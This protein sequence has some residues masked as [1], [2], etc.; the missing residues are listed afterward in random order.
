MKVLRSSAATLAVG[1]F[2]LG[3]VALALFAAPLWYTWHNTMQLSMSSVLETDANRFTEVYRLEGSEGLSNY[4]K[5]RISIPVPSGDRLLM[6]AD[7]SLKPIAGNATAWPKDV[8]AAP[9]D[10][11]VQM[12]VGGTSYQGGGSGG[13]AAG[14]LSSGGLA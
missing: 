9:G 6:F 4:I 8:P 13:A 10:Y 5:A 1:Y 3:L 7:P 12:N 14:R 2:C 11:T